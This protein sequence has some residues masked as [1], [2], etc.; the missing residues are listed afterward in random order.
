MKSISSLLNKIISIE[1]SFVD[2]NQILHWKE[3]GKF[4]AQIQHVTP[5]SSDQIVLFM[6]QVDLKLIKIRIRFT[7]LVTLEM[8]ISYK[9]SYYK[10]KRILNEGEK[11]TSLL[12][13]AQEIL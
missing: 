13:F 10:I 4:R 9:N 7:E 12:L 3:V 5:R 6:Q 2:E 8:R 1:E 11:N